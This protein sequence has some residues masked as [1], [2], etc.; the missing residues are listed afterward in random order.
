MTR[1]ELIELVTSIVQVNGKSEQEIDNL[2]EIFRN[3]VPHPSPTNLIYHE[4]LAIEEI[5]DKALSYKRIQL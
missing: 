1:K 5:V 2:I 4:D 3:N